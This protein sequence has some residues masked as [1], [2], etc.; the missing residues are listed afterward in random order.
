MLG[1]ILGSD[2]SLTQP[3]GGGKLKSMNTI[4]T[5]LQKGFTLVE[6]L[7]VIVIIGILAAISVVAYNGITDK[8]N[9]SVV[10]QEVAQMYKH[11]KAEEVTRGTDFWDDGDYYYENSTY[12]EANGIYT[13]NTDART[14]L[15]SWFGFVPSRSSLYDKD[16]ASI[17]ITSA[18][19]RGADGSESNVLVIYA[20]SKSGKVFVYDNGSLTRVIDGGYDDQKAYI[21]EEIAGLEEN[22]RLIDACVSSPSA[23]VDPD[24]NLFEWTAEDTIRWNSDDGRQAYVYE[25][26]D[27]RDS[28]AGLKENPNILDIIHN[29]SQ[30][31]LAYYAS[32]DTWRWVW[33]VSN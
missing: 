11:I 22:I 27:L 2:L 32:D 29:S 10:Q 9:D 4:H 14:Q 7:I 16:D 18:W 17:V 3:S 23:C 1:F 8:A 6:L 21:E 24:G 15:G 20:R 19:R 28:L 13:L 33:G 25:L 5:K 12:D 26:A 31:S 30:H